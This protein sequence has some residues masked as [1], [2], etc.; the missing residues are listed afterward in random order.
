M[1]T[2]RV[3]W[4]VL[5]CVPSL[6]WPQAP[7]ATGARSTI[8]HRITLDVVVTD[9]TGNPVPGLEQQDFTIFDNKRPQ[10][11][12]AFRKVDGSKNDDLPLRAVFV[13]D[14]VNVPFRAISNARAQLEKYLRQNAGQLPFPMSLVVFNEKS[15]Q[16]QG[17]PTRDGNLLA[18]SVH[19]MGA[20]APRELEGTQFANEIWRLQVSLRALGR[21]TA[22]EMTQPGRKLLIW[23]SPGWPLIPAA[24]DHLGNK[25]LQT[26]FHTVV[27]LSSEL[28]EGRITLYS[29]DPQGTDDAA[30][31]G[32]VYY[33]NFLEGVTSADKFQ[34]GDLT[35]GVVAVQSGGQVLNRSNDISELIGK[36]MADA[37]A[38]Y[39]L[40]FDPGTANHKDEYHALQVKTSKAGILVRTRTGYY[41][42][43]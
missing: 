16:V 23:L 41:A 12:I 17:A 6:A 5:A 30:G 20:G 2:T 43:P 21:L 8:D 33:Q 31:L 9:K 35:L 38:Y 40:S 3:A 14:E 15:T 4:A 29:V 28:R 22:Y 18:D 26:D 27:A 13:I 37:R 19:A 39:I 42:Q 34:S 11:I 24:A 10:P 25:D 32:S 7:P 36:C 1:R